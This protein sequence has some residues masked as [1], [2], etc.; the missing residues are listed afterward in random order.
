MNVKPKN[1]KYKVCELQKLEFL[2]IK[3]NDNTTGKVNFDRNYNVRTFS[4]P[5]TLTYNMCKFLSPRSSCTRKEV[6]ANNNT[7]NAR[8][9]KPIPSQ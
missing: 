5:E 2:S 6:T 3:L 8:S 7:T 1:E 9:M 4:Q